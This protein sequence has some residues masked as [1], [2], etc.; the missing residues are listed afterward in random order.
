[1]KRRVWGALLLFAAGAVWGLWIA[2]SLPSDLPELR[3]RAF[4]HPPQLYSRPLILEL[5]DDPGMAGLPEHL[6][7][8]GWREVPP[9]EPITASRFQRLPDGW[10]FGVRPFP[11]ALLPGDREIES[12]RV[13]VGRDG[14]VA[15]IEDAIG[16][17]RRLVILPP[18]RVGG[19]Y[20]SAAIDRE[21]VSLHQLPTALIDAVLLLEDR[22]FFE[23]AGIDPRRIAGAAWA[24]LRQGGVVE[25][26]STVTQQL[27][28]NLFLT[29]E[30]TFDRKFREAFL[31]LRLER[32]HPK[33][34]ILEA[35]LNDVY[36][37]QRGSIAV[38]GVAAAARHWFGRDVRS[39]D[40]PESA[41]LAGILRGPSLYS[42][43]RRP[44]AALQRRN[45]A[46]RILREA[47]RIDDEGLARALQT[48]LVVHARDATA[49]EG[50]F[51]DGLR[52][53]IQADRDLG[54]LSDR[55][56]RIVT[57]MDARMQGAAHRAVT[58]GLQ[59]LETKRPSLRDGANPLEAALVVLDPK[60]GDV[61]ALIGGR[62]R[63]RSSFNRALY[64]R[65]QPGSA[66]K[67][68]VALAALETDAFDLATPLN[69]APVSI[70]RP[71]G[72]WK[73]TNYDRRF[74]G[75]VSLSE[76][77]ER[78]L[79]LPF[80]RLGQALGPEPILDTAERLG[81]R[82][83]LQ[84]VPA[85]ALGASEVTLMEMTRAYAT[86]ANRGVRHE[87]RRVQL[88]VDP[89]STRVRA[90]PLSPQRAASRGAAAQLTEALQRAVDHGT[91]R[92][93][94]SLG[95]FAPFA[96]KTGTTNGSRD[97][98][99]MGYS[100]DLVVGVWVGFDDGRSIG[101]PGSQA[102][103]PIFAALI[104]ELGRAGE[105]PLPPK[106]DQVSTAL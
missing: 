11:E 31:A 83:R 52:G 100:D 62:D 105:P 75:W 76:A 67:P 57:T 45:L 25:G 86:L 23:H 51:L 3:E 6:E 41:L 59:D 20:G 104:H 64:A 70:E 90:E 84:P 22:R 58:Q 1:M 27:V 19:L 32:R 21:P 81:I 14:K 87:S 38:H 9:S 99:F 24:N 48:P 26:G 4:A 92:R 91:G 2:K 29:R 54:I 7:L 8:S 63:R 55:G 94:R 16:G 44:G 35:Y 65:R 33:T 89:A 10:R 28:K 78:S 42:P 37:G 71:D 39:L 79:N 53:E 17:R 36:L 46:L 102:A 13:R 69:D 101:L 49:A 74:R 5:G 97:A 60:R 73:P 47:G 80:V 50:W 15:S 103:L 96:G 77:I 95:V 93:L 18:V 72:V 68:I 56:L 30:R 88:V 34:E 106:N 12:L 61:L 98:W 40:L 66:F 85:L 82:S 43:K